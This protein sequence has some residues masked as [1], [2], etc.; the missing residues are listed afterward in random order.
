MICCQFFGCKSDLPPPF[1]LWNFFVAKNKDRL[2]KITFGVFCYFFF[3]CRQIPGYVYMTALWST[4]ERNGW[5]DGWTPNIYSR[6]LNS[7]TRLGDYFET[8]GES[9]AASVAHYQLPLSLEVF[10]GLGEE[11]RLF[12]TNIAARDSQGNLLPGSNSFPTHPPYI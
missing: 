3:I 4:Q 8:V 10:G 1:F 2:P 12:W 9:N 11:A 5:L 7:R 6:T